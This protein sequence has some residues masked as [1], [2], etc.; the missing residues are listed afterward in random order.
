MFGIGPQELV[1]V[2]LLTLLVFGPRKLPGM[3]R[4]LGRFVQKAHISMDEFKSEN[5]LGVGA[6]RTSQE[7]LKAGVPGIRSRL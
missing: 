7:G 5:R 1:I 6:R 4:D 2:G 3:A